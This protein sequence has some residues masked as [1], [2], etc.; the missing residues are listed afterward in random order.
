[1]AGR[2]PILIK[3]PDEMVLKIGAYAAAM[4]VDRMAAVVAM[5]DECLKR[6]PPGRRLTAPAPGPRPSPGRAATVVKRTTH[7]TGP[8]A[9][10]TLLHVGPVR[11][12]PGALL[13]K[14]RR[15]S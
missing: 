6:G 3:F 15:P 10:T 8:V 7:E 9:R 2:T 13:D 4:G 11:P 5:V 1:M 14:R 12:R